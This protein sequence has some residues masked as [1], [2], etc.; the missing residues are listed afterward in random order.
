MPRRHSA[1]ISVRTVMPASLRYRC[2]SIAESNNRQ[3]N[4]HILMH[5]NLLFQLLLL[6][7]II[8]LLKQ[9]LITSPSCQLCHIVSMAIFSSCKSSYRF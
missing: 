2:A 4:D 9:S 3:Q 7:S 1:G 8:L 6:I 5:L